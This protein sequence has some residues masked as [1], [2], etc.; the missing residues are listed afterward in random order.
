MIVKELV[1][2]IGDNC[3]RFMEGLQNIS[4]D[5]WKTQDVMNVRYVVSLYILNVMDDKSLGGERADH[6]VCISQILS[7]LLDAFPAV[8]EYFKFGDLKD[9]ASISEES[10]LSSSCLMKLMSKSQFG[11]FVARKYSSQEMILRDR[12]E[13]YTT[14]VVMNSL[15]EIWDGLGSRK[16]AA[17]RWEVLDEKTR[18]E[19]QSR[20]M[21]PISKVDKFKNQGSKVME[22]KSGAKL[23]K[24]LPECEFCGKREGFGVELFKCPCKL[25]AYCG[26]ECQKKNWQAHKQVCKEARPVS[27]K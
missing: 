3:E 24:K 5:E 7:N 8:L 25:V 2:S 11:I 16:R 15:V 1:N 21:A 22:E 13:P 10:F 4:P 12:G 18:E 23:P 9:V 17:Y 20:H 27:S 6:A 26:K 19:L 14:R